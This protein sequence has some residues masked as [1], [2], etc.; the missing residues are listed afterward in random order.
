MA[1][2]GVTTDMQ[3]HLQSMDSHYREGQT[4]DL[5]QWYEADV[6]RMRPEGIRKPL[7]QQ[8]I[9]QRIAE[10]EK[11]PPPAPAEAPP[12]EPD[13]AA[14]QADESSSEHSEAAVAGVALPSEVRAAASSKAKARGRPGAK[15]KAKPP[16]PKRLRL[17]G[18]RV[19]A[20]GQASPKK[21]AKAERSLAPSSMGGRSSRG[22][23]AAAT[24]A[25]KL[26]QECLDYIEK[27]PLESV[28]AATASNMTIYNAGRKVEQIEGITPGTAEA[29]NLTGHLALVESAKKI[30][31]SSLGALP[32][33]QMMPVLSE[34]MPHVDD[35]SL[36]PGEWQG[37][38]FTKWI[39]HQ[40]LQS[41][42]DI[43]QFVESLSLVSEGDLQR[44][45]CC[46]K[47]TLRT[48]WLASSIC[49]VS[50]FGQKLLK[51]KA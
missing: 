1:T 42:E 15:S 13:K 33:D 20:K 38:V 4:R 26:G 18:K 31:L 5:K 24:T 7:S 21:L 48:K 23:M 17:S 44:I 49:A 16:T 11:A 29:V 3:Q 10:A 46:E 34:V 14:E 28:L 27:I 37:M 40:P 25:E 35:A 30:S 32:F 12:P 36:L 22:G 47:R 43:Q 19:M 39:R 6:L 50:G 45:E 2:S 51:T 41:D 9:L 8:D